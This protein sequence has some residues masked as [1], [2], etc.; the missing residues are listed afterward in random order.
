MPGKG[1]TFEFCRKSFLDEYRNGIRSACRDDKGIAMQA[2]RMEAL[3]DFVEK[4]YGMRLT[5]VPTKSY[6]SLMKVRNEPCFPTIIETIRMA[7]R[8]GVN[9]VPNGRKLTADKPNLSKKNVDDII[10]FAK[11]G[12][13]GRSKV[14]KVTI[15]ENEKDMI[16]RL[17]TRSLSGANKKDEIAIKDFF[18]RHFG[19]EFPEWTID[20]KEIKKI[21]ESIT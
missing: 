7:I 6:S 16:S 21:N 8:T 5:I 10:S 20:L 2:H 18:A 19:K 17:R 1:I 14:I 11:N 15:N 9:P 4:K 13:Y 3:S 12:R